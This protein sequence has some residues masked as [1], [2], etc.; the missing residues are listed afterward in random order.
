MDD[1]KLTPISFNDKKG[2]V[3]SIYQAITRLMAGQ[4]IS[5]KISHK[6]NLKTLAGALDSIAEIVQ[7]AA[8]AMNED[9]EDEEKDDDD[10]DNDD[11]NWWKESKK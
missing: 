3:A 6:T 4:D 9:D 7:A 1:I 11:A 5:I 2:Y 8:R 10:E